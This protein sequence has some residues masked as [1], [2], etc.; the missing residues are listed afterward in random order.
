MS[1]RPG[2]CRGAPPRG[3][4]PG[5]AR[6][7]PAA[8]GELRRPIALEPQEFDQASDGIVVHADRQALADRE[9][10]PRAFEHEGYDDDCGDPH[11]SLACYQPSVMPPR[12]DVELGYRQLQRHEGD[13]GPDPAGVVRTLRK[14]ITLVNGY[15]FGRLAD[16]TRAGVTDGLEGPRPAVPRPRAGAGGRGAA[17]APGR[18][19]RRPSRPSSGPPRRRRPYWPPSHTPAAGRGCFRTMSATCRPLGGA[20]EDGPCK[21]CGV[22]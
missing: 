12:V 15:R 20:F 2:R 22:R 21:G 18:G 13:A 6:P 9:K 7:R 10:A 1:T 19:L 8:V 17:G 4:A 16:A 5:R 11:R 14:P 3:L